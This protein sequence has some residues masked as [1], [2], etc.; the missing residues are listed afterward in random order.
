MDAASSAYGETMQARIQA[1]SR[2]A[3][4][5]T[6]AEQE[7]TDMLGFLPGRCHSSEQKGGPRHITGEYCTAACPVPRS[8]HC[9]L[10]FSRYTLARLLTDIRQQAQKGSR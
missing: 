9:P 1:L 6:G 2:R 8:S 3:Q 10:S 4:Q 5:S 7:R